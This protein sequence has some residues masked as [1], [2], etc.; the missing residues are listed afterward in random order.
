[1]ATTQTPARYRTIGYVLTGATKT[2][3]LTCGAGQ[4]IDI[5]KLT[6]CASAG[7]SAAA[8]VYFDDDSAG[9]EYTVDYESSVPT[10][11]FKDI[12]VCP[13]HLDPS[14]TISVAGENAM[15]VLITMIESGRNVGIT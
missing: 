4:Y 8:S 5:V 14:D 2:V 7:S 11:G 15:H 3:V 10:T 9:V 12:D 13:L 6:I 1:M